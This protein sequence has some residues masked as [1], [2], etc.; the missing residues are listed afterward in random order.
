MLV[1]WLSKNTQQQVP[2]E[3]VKFQVT[4]SLG[5]GEPTHLA[6]EDGYVSGT[7]KTSQTAD[8]ASNKGKTSYTKKH[9]NR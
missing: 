9:Q 3:A 8:I 4:D 1:K 5:V 6:L 2:T 7:G